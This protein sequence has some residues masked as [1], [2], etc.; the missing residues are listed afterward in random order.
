MTKRTTSKIAFAFLALAFAASS[1][2]K[3]TLF[4]APLDALDPSLAFS[5]ADRIE[6]TAIGMYDGLQNANYFGGRVLIYA[7]QRGVDES[8]NTYFGNIGFIPQLLAGDGTVGAAWRDAYNSIYQANYFLQNFPANTPLVSPEKA[9]QYIGEAKFIRALVY[10]YTE[11]LWAQP[12]NKSWKA[13]DTTTLGIPLVLTVSADP[14]AASNQVPRNTIK[15]VYAQIESDLLD[16]KAKLPE[17]PADAFTRVARANR[18]SALALLSRLYLYEGEWAKAA[19]YADSVFKY[20]STLGLNASP[21]QTFQAPY[22]TKESIF[23]VAM[24]GADNPNTNNSLGQHYGA[25]ARGDINISSDYVNLMD[26][27]HDARYRKLM[28]VVSKLYW[29]TKY[30]GITTDFVPVVRYAEILLTKAEA[31]AR[32]NS[33]VDATALALVNQVRARSN[34]VLPIV[35]TTQDELIN[36]IVTE[37][38]IEL[39]FEGHGVFEFQRTGRDIPSH[40]NQP[41]TPWAS[42]RSVLPIPD[43]DRQKNPNL[44]QNPGY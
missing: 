36:A 40:Y 11:N 17:P 43:Y 31:L 10:F 7:D 9:N 1:C 37:R 13:G 26:T 8:P 34:A 39:A 5:S 12:Y 28:Q 44:A 19:A 27:L 18:T 30:P 23:S 14:F 4:E 22:T 38:R 16:A 33:G 6:K 42:Q 25:K 35:A 32:L 20:N 3:S 24:N 29:T 15:E 21:E 2:K 41:V